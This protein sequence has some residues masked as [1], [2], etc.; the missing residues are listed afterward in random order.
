MNKLNCNVIRDLLPTYVDDICSAETKVIIEEHIQ[1]C[2]DCRNLVKMIRE[3][4]FV[5]QEADNKEIDYMKKIRKHF[6]GKSIVCFVLLLLIA[7][8]GIVISIQNYGMVPLSFYYGMPPIFM[9]AAY[10]MVSDYISMSTNTKWK[11]IMA[12]IGGGAF[13]YTI[14]LGFLMVQWMNNDSVPFS[15]EVNAIG[16]CLTYQFLILGMIQM[17]GFLAAWLVS[18]KTANS[19]VIL[20]NMNIVGCC[21][22]LAFISMLRELS[23]ME[24][25]IQV[26]N[27]SLFI[28]LLEGTLLTGLFFFLDWKKR[29]K[30][31]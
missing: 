5:S 11:I 18:L 15:I 26:R 12:I 27:Q 21:T 25:F 17:A 4:E 14:L 30:I 3:T 31:S 29:K 23:T 16:I 10:L 28:M 8:L 24:N 13:A 19:H 2:N 22:S 1:K 7:V 9:V 20:M 6:T